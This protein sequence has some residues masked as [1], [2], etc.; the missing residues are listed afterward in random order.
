MEI[1]NNYIYFTIILIIFSIIFPTNGDYF[2]KT[3]IANL[4][5]LKK[6]TLHF[7]LHDILSGKNPSAILAA[8][9]NITLGQKS[10][11]P[12]GS[13]Y[14]IDDPITI[15]PEANSTVI[16]NA[17][18]LYLSSSKDTF[19]LVMYVDF[20]FTY[21][22]F[23]G[24][25]I[26]IFSRNPVSEGSDRE[27]GVV[28]GRGKFKLAKGFAKVQTYYLDIKSGDAILEYNVDVYHY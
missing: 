15:G 24:S 13:V 4:P 23:N 7:Y 28:G 5:I 3:K 26:S 10:A 21:G 18:G 16:G 19:S 6:T 9:P 14:A 25:S 12:F 17:Q 20:G 2:S 1:K 8:R 27:V 22:K 11:T